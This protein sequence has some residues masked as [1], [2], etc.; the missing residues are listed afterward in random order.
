LPLAEIHETLIIDAR[1]FDT[2]DA[3]AARNHRAGAGGKPDTVPSI[4]ARKETRFVE[5]TALL[6]AIVPCPESVAATPA[7]RT[8]AA[9]AIF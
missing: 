5:I 6:L 9:I 4:G 3:R 2:G 7:P 8:A 1:I